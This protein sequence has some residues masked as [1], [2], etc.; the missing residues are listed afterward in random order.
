MECPK[1]KMAVMVES[2]TNGAT[3]TH[4]N[5]PDIVEAMLECPDCHTIFFGTLYL[6]DSREVEEYAFKKQEEQAPENGQEVSRG[7]GK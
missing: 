4:E 3:Y 2:M 5:V 6:G 7:T 1:C